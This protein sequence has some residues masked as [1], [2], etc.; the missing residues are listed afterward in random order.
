MQYNSL[1]EFLKACANEKEAVKFFERR[2]CRKAFAVPKLIT[3][4]GW[5]RP[6]YKNWLQT[7]NFNSFVIGFGRWKTIYR[8]L[9]GILTTNGVM[10]EPFA[11]K[12][13]TD[14]ESG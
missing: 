5:K 8:L 2:R 1:Y 12:G 11:S 10:W 4:H 3:A 13:N 14:E 6:A 9:C 7:I